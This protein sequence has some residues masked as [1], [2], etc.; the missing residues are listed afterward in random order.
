MDIKHISL[1]KAVQS[2]WS[3]KTYHCQR[4]EVHVPFYSF[5]S[6]LRSAYNFLLSIRGVK[7]PTYAFQIDALRL[8]QCANTKHTETFVFLHAGKMPVVLCRLLLLFLAL[9]LLAMVLQSNDIKN[10][11]AGS[12]LEMR[13][14]NSNIKNFL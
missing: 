4:N 14:C 12:P 8:F 6:A 9:S 5:N 13:N 1:N 2:I 7:F 11:K 10:I 3:R